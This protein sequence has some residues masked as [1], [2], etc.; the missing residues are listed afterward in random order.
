MKGGVGEWVAEKGVQDQCVNKELNTPLTALD[1]LVDDHVV[2]ARTGT[3]TP[4][5]CRRQPW[6]RREADP[7][8]IAAPP[9]RRSPPGRE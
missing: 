3:R 2:P 4:R 7:R 6:C 9:R 8:P 1:V 5:R